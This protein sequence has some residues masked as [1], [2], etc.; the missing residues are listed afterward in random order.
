VTTKRLSLAIGLIA[1]AAAG[2]YVFVYLYRWE[3]NRALIAG[4]I[5]LAAEIALIG[6]M[7]FDRLKRIEE[8]LDDRDHAR[9][10]EQIQ[11]TAPEPKHPFAWLSGERDNLNVFVPVLMGAGIVF[12]A[13]AWAVERIAAVTAKPILEK[14]LA[15]RLAPISVPT[16]VL[17]TG[18]VQAPAPRRYYLL[19]LVRAV[20]IV[21]LVLVVAQGI[22][23][24]GD[25]TQNR[26][27]AL[28]T[29]STEVT[30]AIDARSA[31]IGDVRATRTLWAAC[32]TTVDSDLAGI[33]RTGG[34]IHL[35]VEP[36]LG[37]YSFRRLKGCFEDATV[38]GIRADVR[39]MGE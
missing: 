8:K 28:T 26:P 17:T 30:L 7:L 38:D 20:A 27:D 32:S 34:S 39:D 14:R 11:D 33:T 22:D 35:V 15:A 9:T 31:V 4:V 36:A 37:R 12:S 25:L 23:L 3:W 10:V 16:G 19:P 1:L 5:F 13:L 29:G 18:A 24:L 2:F 21:L 6:A